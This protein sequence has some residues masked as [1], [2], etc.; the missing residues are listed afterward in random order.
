MCIKDSHDSPLSFHN[1]PTSAACPHQHSRPCSASGAATSSGGA[2][3]VQC[4][5]TRCD[6]CAQNW[7]DCRSWIGQF[8][9][10]DGVAGSADGDFVV[11]KS[12]RRTTAPRC[13]QL[14]PSLPYRW[15]LCWQ[16]V[17]QEEGAPNYPG[18]VA[19][20]SYRRQLVVVSNSHKVAQ[21][22]V[23]VLQ[24]KMK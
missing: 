19:G 2:M 14:W 17:K 12:S 6:R 13:R 18:L 15:T 21:C 24:R 16:L 20:G 4:L 8:S 22:V 1:S 3:I 7:S 11:C 9:V 23:V 10:F 5:R